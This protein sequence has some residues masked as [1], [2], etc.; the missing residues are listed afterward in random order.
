MDSA[1][2]SARKVPLRR[3]S[4]ARARDGALIGQAAPRAS[5][6]AVGS[7]DM[8]L[9]PVPGSRRPYRHLDMRNRTPALRTVRNIVRRNNRLV[10]E[11]P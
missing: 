5:L 4:I 11:R 9:L 8:L 6:G 2:V 3:L 10:L 1:G 7:G